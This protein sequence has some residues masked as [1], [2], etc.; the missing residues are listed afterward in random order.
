MKEAIIV[1]ALTTPLWVIFIVMMIIRWQEYRKEKR[2]G[3]G[4]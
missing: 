2:G 4:K 3:A 1:I